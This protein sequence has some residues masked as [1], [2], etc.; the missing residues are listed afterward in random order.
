MKWAGSG[1]PVK[2]LVGFPEVALGG[3][4]DGALALGR[5]PHELYDPPRYVSVSS[6]QARREGSQQAGVC[7]CHGTPGLSGAPSM[8][9]GQK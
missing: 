7:T 1:M 5:L 3:R 4:G 9:L 6:L 2:G 8:R